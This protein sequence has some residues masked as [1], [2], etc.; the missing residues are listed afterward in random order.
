MTDRPAACVRVC[1]ANGSIWEDE[2]GEADNVQRKNKMRFYLFIG[3]L[4]FLTMCY[5]KTEFIR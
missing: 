2:D 3:V 5:W 1:G 4:F